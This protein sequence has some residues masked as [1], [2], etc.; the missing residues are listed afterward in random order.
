MKTFNFNSKRFRQL[1]DRVFL[2]LYSRQCLNGVIVYKGI[3]LRDIPHFESEL[4]SHIVKHER[5]YEPTVNGNFKLVKNE[6]VAANR[7]LAA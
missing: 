6:Y 7:K 4:E 3:T 5:F 1:S 2:D